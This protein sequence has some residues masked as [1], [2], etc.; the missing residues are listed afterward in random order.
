MS[1]SL[2]SSLCHTF[3]GTVRNTASRDRICDNRGDI[4]DAPALFQYSRRKGAF[5]MILGIYYVPDASVDHECAVCVYMKDLAEVLCPDKSEWMC[6][7][8]LK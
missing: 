2:L 6:G 7:T 4:D 8:N 1:K 3:R 5:I